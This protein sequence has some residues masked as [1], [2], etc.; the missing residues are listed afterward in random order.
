MLPAVPSPV[1]RDYAGRPAKTPD[2]AKIAVVE[3]FTAASRR[4]PAAALRH[5]RTA[6]DHAAVLSISHEYPRWTDHTA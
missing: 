2:Q 6:L 3:A 4:Q 1:T 5:A